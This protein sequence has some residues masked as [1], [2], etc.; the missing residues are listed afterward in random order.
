MKT[1][2]NYSIL[3]ILILLLFQPKIAAQQDINSKIDSI[4][5]T[6]YK[7]N[8]PGAVFLAA[9][10][11]EILYKKAFGLANISL[12]V[13]MKT[14]YIFEIGSITKQFTA[15][16]ILML[17]EQGKLSLQDYI[18]KYLTDYPTD[19]HNIT[20]HHLLTHTSGIKNY[21]SIKKL[22]DIRK[23]DLTPTALIDF[24]KNEP[25]DF[26]PG[27]KFKY[28]NSGYIILGHIIETISGQSY[29]SFIEEHIFKKLKMC[30]SSY[31]VRRKITKNRITGYTSTDKGYKKPW[32]FSYSLAFAAGS[33]TSTV[34]DMLKWQ[35]ALDKNILVKNSI[36]N[37]A[38]KNYTTNN[39]E[40]IN[41]GY[42]WNIKTLNGTKS[43]RHG[44]SIFGFK[45]MSVYLP[46][47]DIYVI[48]L[49]NCDCNSPTQITKKIAALFMKQ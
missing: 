41:Y 23:D 13:P 49:T 24:F 8:G 39:G 48:G 27:E 38:F 30:S 12:D 31:A 3:L 20:I 1:N 2:F 15:I 44:G 36:L 11:G 4:L 10:N 22:N 46:K 35:N 18:T 26:A 34:D 45:S 5:A 9:K 16:A 17:V 33:L 32:Y 6:Q 7:P 42:G 28:N 14:E 37:K 21:T 43:R 29:A 40:S 47:E 19:G 25:M